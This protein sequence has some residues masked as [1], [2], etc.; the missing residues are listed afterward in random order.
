MAPNRQRLPFPRRSAPTTARRTHERRRT[1]TS[2]ALR[3]KGLDGSMRM[4]RTRYL[5]G[6]DAPSATAN[7]RDCLGNPVIPTRTCA[8]A[9]QAGPTRTTA[10]AIK[11]LPSQA[12]AEYR[13]RALALRCTVKDNVSDSQETRRSPDYDCNINAAL[14]GDLVVKVQNS[15]THFA[16]IGVVLRRRA[17]CIL[18]PHS[19]RERKAL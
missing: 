2:S 15:V 12:G 9:R 3:R 19:V 6:A 1:D 5:A 17:T 13:V 4:R 7:A 14:R 16:G 10:G 11:R 8:L 18:W